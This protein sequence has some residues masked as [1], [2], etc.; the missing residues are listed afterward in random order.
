V[1]HAL[2]SSGLLRVEVCRARVFQF[3]SRLA[4][5]RRWVMHVTPS[6]RLRRVQIEDGC[7]DAIGCVGPCYTCFAIFI[8]LSILVFCLGL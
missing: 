1:G 4:E 2:R 7:V 3:T 5:T 8:V 6:W